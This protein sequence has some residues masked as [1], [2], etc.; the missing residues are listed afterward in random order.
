M[1]HPSR[2][3]SQSASSRSWYGFLAG[4]DRLVS[5]TILAMLLF[6]AFQWDS[7]RPIS[8][9]WM[10]MGIA[11]L[12]TSQEVTADLRLTRLERCMWCRQHALGSAQVSVDGQDGDVR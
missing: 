4:L 2:T 10:L 11:L 1:I 5:Y 6:G 8:L 7:G 9:P 3:V 12:L